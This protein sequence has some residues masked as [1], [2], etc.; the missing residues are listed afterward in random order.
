M[1]LAPSHRPSSARG[2]ASAGVDVEMIMD[3]EALIDLESVGEK[4]QP[5]TAPYLP[6]DTKCGRTT[7][8]RL[9]MVMSPEEPQNS[10]LES[11][12]AELEN[13]IHGLYLVLH[14]ER[15]QKESQVSAL[16]CQ[17]AELENDI[18]GL[19]LVLHKERSQKDGLVERFDSV[20]VTVDQLISEKDG[21]N[22][23]LGDIRA[24][25][26]RTK[27]MLQEGEI[28]LKQ[29][30]ERLESADKKL[31][32]EGKARE[33]LE[34]ELQRRQEEVGEL[35]ANLRRKEEE[36]DAIQKVQKEREESF[37]KRL[38]DTEQRGQETVAELAS[39]RQALTESQKSI[40][41]KDQWISLLQAKQRDAETRRKEAQK[42]L[43]TF[44][45]RSK[46]RQREHEQQIR[47]ADGRARENEALYIEMQ[48]QTQE[49]LRKADKMMMVGQEELGEALE[50]IEHLNNEKESLKTAFA[51]KEAQVKALESALK[52]ELKSSHES[53]SAIQILND[54]IDILEGK[55]LA[56]SRR[57]ENYSDIQRDSIQQKR[58][59]SMQLS[60]LQA[61]YE[62]LK[63]TSRE[64]EK[65]AEEMARKMSQKDARIEEQER[66]IK[67]LKEASSPS[68]AVV[69]CIDGSGS[70]SGSSISDAN[71]TFQK[72]V[73][74][75]RSRN[76]LAHVAVL[77]H[78]GN[79]GV[80]TVREL[81]KVDSS[82]ETALGHVSARG[83]EKWLVTLERAKA[84]LE[85][86]KNQHARAS[87]RII[88]IGDGGAEWEYNSSGSQAS[89]RQTF[90]NEFKRDGILVH[91]VLTSSGYNSTWLEH[92]STS[93]RYGSTSSEGGL[94]EVSKAAGGMNFHSNASST[95]VSEEL[96]GYGR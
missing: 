47:A 94:S 76:S 30:E 80:T 59:L 48:K 49:D 11:Q 13:E 26:E 66:C 42:T 71:V 58:D 78:N 93:S 86:F 16:E 68:E 38:K 33:S 29:S 72:I 25:L 31:E 81:S 92:S 90:F 8:A 32:E 85:T 83:G 39:L 67:D 51:V 40:D 74:G 14:K 34:S 57:V 79:T 41:G 70:M 5:Q 37:S 73:S 61:D 54:R 77:V 27:S 19:Y 52:K 82:V 96:V 12:V 23:D 2:A 55:L 69:F 3:I 35:A 45:E 53:E 10:A 60:R 21:M 15:S 44:E 89:Q 91:T 46:V 28:G 56:E 9:D 18:H 50:R 36:L 7:T 64:Q 95:F 24:E 43:A 20:M 88:C 75:I 62:Q 63:G 1:V 17:V 87:C 84:M 22:R 65:A 6:I 4:T